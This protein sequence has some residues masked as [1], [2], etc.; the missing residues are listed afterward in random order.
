MRCPVLPAP[1]P[2]VGPVEAKPK[3]VAGPA[4]G[5]VLPSQSHGLFGF[6]FLVCCIVGTTHP[7]IGYGYQAPMDMMGPP[8]FCIHI[9]AG[10]PATHFSFT[11]PHVP[12]TS[13][14]APTPSCRSST[15]HTL[16]T[17]Q[18]MIMIKVGMV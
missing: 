13:R 7:S 5:F 6:G 2:R 17:G 18:L 3:P 16:V 15:P 10:N 4:P 14:L 11:H 12:S 1:P 9:S 8:V